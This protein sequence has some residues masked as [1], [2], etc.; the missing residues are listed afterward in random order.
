MENVIYLML[1]VDHQVDI[2]Y[3]WDLK[4]LLTVMSYDGE[5]KTM[6]RVEIS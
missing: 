1:N 3:Y 2:S 4:N 5:Y 6:I